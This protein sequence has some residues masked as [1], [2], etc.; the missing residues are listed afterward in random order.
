[1][2]ALLLDGPGGPATLRLARVDE[3]TVEAGTVRVAIEAC[4]LNPV[5]ATSLGTGHPDW[6][7][8]HV[9]GLDIAGRV[10]AVGD[11]VGH[12]SVGD[13]VAVHADLRRGGGL[14]EVAVV[15]ARAAAAVPEGLGAIEAA[16]LPCAGLT[17]LQAVARR[18]DVEPGDTVLVTGASGGVGGFAVQLAVLAGARVI[19]A[20][21]PEHAA[22]V[23]ALGAHDVIDPRGEDVAARVRDLTGGRGV[24]AVIDAVS[25]DSATAGLALLA[26]GGGIACVAGRADLSRVPEFTLAPSVHEIALG[27]AYAAEDERSI[28]WLAEGLELLM[29][30]VVAEELD[31]LVTGTVPLEEAPA[32]L[33]RVAERHTRGT[34]VVAMDPAA[35]G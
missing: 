15:D 5:D 25:A 12:L 22:A 3:P 10:Q 23:H 29:Q 21:S 33:A 24:D 7:Y 8:P 11:G 35:E 2:R 30:L 14:A 18:L 31:P 16:A 20:A 6:S 1:M 27:A 4:G 32:T 26:H 17:A 19:G 9:P 13:L 28:A 34:V